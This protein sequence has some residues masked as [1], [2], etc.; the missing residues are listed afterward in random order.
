MQHPGTDIGSSAPHWGKKEHTTSMHVPPMIGIEVS[1]GLG[2]HAS[3][4]N[5]VSHVRAVSNGNMSSIL[6]S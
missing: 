5:L 6:T 3:A 1:R 2:I 4:G